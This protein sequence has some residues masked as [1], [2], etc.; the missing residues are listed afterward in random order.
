MADEVR[1]PAIKDIV[2]IYKDPLTEKKL[3][4]YAFV[5]EILQEDDEYFLLL[6]SFLGDQHQRKAPRKYKKKLAGEV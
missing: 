1:C 2:M 6:V 4:G 3:E 5:W